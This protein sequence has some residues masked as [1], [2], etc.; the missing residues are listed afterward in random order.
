MIKLPLRALIDQQ[1]A[2]H[3][4][5][6]PSTTPTSINRK[7]QH[8][9]SRTT[10][11]NTDGGRQDRSGIRTKPV[12]TRGPGNQLGQIGGREECQVYKI[13]ARTKSGRH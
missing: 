13:G 12:S 1:I 4:G 5:D 3:L 11:M 8:T 9:A 10:T 2:A 6:G 7:Q